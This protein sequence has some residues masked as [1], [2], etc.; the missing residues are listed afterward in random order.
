MDRK[1]YLEDRRPSHETSLSSHKVQTIPQALFL[2][3]VA[4]EVR[5]EKMRELDVHITLLKLVG[6]LK[7]HYL[8]NYLANRIM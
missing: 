7:I 3:V 5:E 6:V 4:F 1:R 2:C 8:P